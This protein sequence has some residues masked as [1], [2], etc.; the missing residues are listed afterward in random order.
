MRSS[1]VLRNLRRIPMAGNYP[2]GVALALL[3]LSPF[4]ILTTATFLMQQQIMKDLHATPFQLQLTAGLANAG[5]AFGAVAAADIVQ[6]V[7]RRHVYLMCE[8]GFVVASILVLSAPGIGQFMAGA[9][10][11]GLCTGMLLV[12]ALPPLFFGQPV[13]KLQPTAAAVSLGLFGMVA[14]GPLMGGIVGDFGGW[15]YLFT[16]VAVLA[17]IG[18]SIGYVTFEPNEPPARRARFD[19]LAS[20]LALGTTVLPFFGVAW[21]THGTFTSTAFLVPVFVGLAIGVVLI[22]AQY[23]KPAPLMPVRPISNTLP[24]TGT[25]AAMLAGAAFTTL[26]EL[27][28]V[29]LIDVAHYGPLK[30]GALITTQLAGVI[31]GATLLYFSLPTRYTPYLALSGVIGIIVGASILMGIS[32]TNADVIVPVAAV[33]LGFGAGAGVTPGLFMAGLSVPVWQIGSTFAL[34]ELLRSEAA[35]LVGPVLLHLA[36]IEDFGPSGYHLAVEITLGVT[37][38]GALLLVG[39]YLLGGARPHAPELHEWLSGTT[40]GYH[41]PPIAAAIRN[42]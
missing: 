35:F 31:A 10:V 37:A 20:P 27:T 41:S 12:A 5:Y 1:P 13:N 2:A 4:L 38:G 6:R 39:L 9:I 40:T 30:V 34:V 19:L 16:G 17:A 21:L 8:A 26:L 22:V 23:R 28:E 25:A 11:Q 15:R 18:F 33:F 42:V 29:Y 32:P 24:V 7:P 14:F 36:L 3:A